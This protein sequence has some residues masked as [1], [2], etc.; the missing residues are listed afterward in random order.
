MSN[1]SI[2]E[3]MNMETMNDLANIPN[4]VRTQQYIDQQDETIERL[5][6]QYNGL[7]SKFYELMDDR[8]GW[9]ARE[10]ATIETARMFVQQGALDRDEFNSIRSK[11]LDQKREEVRIRNGRA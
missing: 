2:A 11:I 7:K 3:I 10:E 4:Q 8:D 1:L 5:Q 9:Q 6:A